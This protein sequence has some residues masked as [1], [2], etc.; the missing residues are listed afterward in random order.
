M[1]R[2]VGRKGIQYSNALQNYT[3]TVRTGADWAKLARVVNPKNGYEMNAIELVDFPR[4]PIEYRLECVD[5]TFG[6]DSEE[7]D[8]RCDD[9]FWFTQE[10]FPYEIE[11]TLEASS[12]TTSTQPNGALVPLEITHHSEGSGACEKNWVTAL[13]ALE[14]SAFTLEGDNQ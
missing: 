3:I 9:G 10:G 12:M 13:L 1:D 14:T 6:I 11:A 2:V 8:D 4:E 5:G 7:I